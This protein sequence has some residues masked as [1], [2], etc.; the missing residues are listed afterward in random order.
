MYISRSILLEE[1]GNIMNISGE[2]IPYVVKELIDLMIED[3]ERDYKRYKE[4][5]GLYEIPTINSMLVLYLEQQKNRIKE[6][7]DEKDFEKV[8]GMNKK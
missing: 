1:N 2:N 3:F 5:C 7:V 4:S 8:L 6:I